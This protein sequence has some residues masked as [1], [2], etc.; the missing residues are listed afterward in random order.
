MLVIFTFDAQ[1]A[2][3]SSVPF[4]LHS[5]HLNTPRMATNQTQQNVWQWQS[6]AFGVGQ[7]N[8]SLVMNLRFPGQYF[9]QESGLH[10]NYF[11]DY[12]PET[13][14]YVESDPIGLKGGPNT[15]GYVGG[16]P[17]RFSDPLGLLA[18]EEFVWVPPVIETIATTTGTAVSTVALTTLA[19]VALTAFP[20]SLGNGDLYDE[21]CK[22]EDPDK[23]CSPVEGTMCFEGPDTTHPHG[24]LGDHYH[25]FQ[26]QRR[27]ENGIK[28]CFWKYLGGKVGVGVLEFPTAGMNPCSSYAGFTG[29]GG[30]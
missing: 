23:P 3:A 21:D 5:D 29:R 20:S 6:D 30:R 8:G 4:Y 7:A 17:L 14:R 24:G 25:I 13:G 22:E 18:G 28:I 19:V 12:D 15:F 9:D 1:G 27:Y 2:I 10:Y 16:N 11:R 26:M